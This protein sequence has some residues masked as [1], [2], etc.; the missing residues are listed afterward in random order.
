MWKQFCKAY[1]KKLKPI[2][3]GVKNINGKVITNPEGK[4]PLT[5]NHFEQRMRVRPRHQETKEIGKI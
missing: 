5:I 1:K 4:K 3:T 2:P